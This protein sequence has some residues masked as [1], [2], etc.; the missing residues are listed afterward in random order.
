MDIWW[1]FEGM[2]LL[3]NH[4]HRSRLSRCYHDRHSTTGQ[5]SVTSQVLSFTR[6]STTLA[7]IEGLGTRL[8]IGL[9]PAQAFTSSSACLL[10][11]LQLH[12]I[13]RQGRPTR[14]NKL[15]LNC[16]I[17]SLSRMLSTLDECL[18]LHINTHILW[19]LLLLTPIK[20]LFSV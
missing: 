14:P 18:R 12:C 16:H 6:P 4:S 15:R 3:V 11:V 7:V 10:A 9:V 13:K 17:H 19:G 5:S 2:A 8:D 1:T 20:I